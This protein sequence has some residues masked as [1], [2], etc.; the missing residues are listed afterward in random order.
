MSGGLG[1]DHRG[2]NAG[3]RIE[4]TVDASDALAEIL[5]QNNQL[6]ANL[7][8]SLER[9]ERLMLELQQKETLLTKFRP[10]QGIVDDPIAK[11]DVPISDKTMID[12][13]RKRMIQTWGRA[14]DVDSEGKWVQTAAYSKFTLMVNE[15]LREGLRRFHRVL[16][17]IR[18][19]EGVGPDAQQ[20]K[21]LQ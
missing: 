5:N 7:A 1:R 3:L 9:E 17:R 21:P 18:L 12:E 2:Q 14:G 19:A 8:D 15:L 16:P 6:K 20:A 4:H 10:F 13:L 11:L